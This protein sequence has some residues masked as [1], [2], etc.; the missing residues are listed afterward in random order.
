M[1]KIFLQHI[2]L[3]KHFPHFPH[4]PPPPSCLFL[5]SNPLPGQF[6]VAIGLTKTHNKMML[7]A[8]H[9]FAG[10]A[11]V[12]CCI[13]MEKKKTW[14]IQLANTQQQQQQTTPHYNS[15]NFNFCIIFVFSAAAAT[16]SLFHSHSLCLSFSASCVASNFC[17]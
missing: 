4:S 17:P 9:K 5:Y 8:A 11:S 2:L 13:R 16:F 1:K 10:H 6:L 7:H 15:S 3:A 14:Q 12:L